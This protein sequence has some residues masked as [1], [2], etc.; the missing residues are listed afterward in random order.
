MGRFPQVNADYCRNHLM[1]FLQR[2]FYGPCLSVS[3]STLRCSLSARHSIPFG[4][5]F[6]VNIQPCHLALTAIPFLGL[7]SCAVLASW[8]EESQIIVKSTADNTSKNDFRSRRNHLLGSHLS[9]WYV[10]ES[11]ASTWPVHRSRSEAQN[12]SLSSY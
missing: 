10:L 1:A 5:K 3:K 11:A 4:V 9:I 8:R 12:R 2:T 6:P 7:S